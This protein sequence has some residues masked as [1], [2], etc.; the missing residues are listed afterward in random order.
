M[1]RAS[2]FQFALAIMLVSAVLATGSAQAQTYTESVLYSF[3]GSPDGAYPGGGSL[4]RDAQ[5]NLYGTTEGGGPDGLGTV[6][7]VDTSGKETVL[8]SFTGTGGDG[9]GPYAGLVLDTQDNLYGTTQYGGANA[10]GT[11]FKVDTTGKETVLYSF[12]GT[13]GDGAGPTAGLVRDAQGNLYGTTGGG[14]ANGWGTVFKV[15]T[16]G[17][18]TV[19]YSFTGT[20]GDGAYPYAGLVRDAQGNLYGTTPGG[21]AYEYGT[22][23]KVDTTG[24]ET[25]LYSFTGTGGDGTRP[26]AGLVRDAQGNLYG[27]TAHSGNSNYYGTVFEVDTTGNETV[28]Y[29][30]TG[31]GGD[32]AYPVAGLVMDAQGNL[33]GTTQFGGD[34]AC[35]A[36]A[37]CGTAFKLDT[38]GKETVLHTFTGTPDGNNP[39]AGLVLDAQGNLY[40]TTEGGGADGLG[41]VFELHFMLGLAA[42]DPTLAVPKCDLPFRSCD[43]G[44]SLLLGKDNMAGG[45]EPN[46]PNTIHN[47]CADGTAG[48]FHVD[49]SIDR[50]TVAAINGLSMAQGSIVRISATVWVADPTQDALDLYYA[51]NANN[52]TWTYIATLVPRA[53]GSQTLSAL[54]RIGPGQ[55][56]AV[57][58]NFRKGGTRS[59]CSTGDYD[60]HD[61][62][63]FAVR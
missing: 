23:F 42:Y 52:P 55:L 19:L 11:V 41:T 48:T 40:G 31:T 46:E 49:E 1:Q 45:A 36:P 38:S 56:Q 21:G 26:Y 10:W 17:K 37:G 7:K 25:V 8:Y 22:V 24:T 34:L 44:P 12:T 2:S 16:T 30:F 27:T 47:S 15:D 5:G 35:G 4:V 20:G 63:T 51:T 39:V 33:Y 61:D 3:T 32:G 53:K 29:S 14:G 58:A 9:A 50:L 28:L 59:S 60:D 43:S 57:R 6:F 13:G 62:L 18:E 54:Y